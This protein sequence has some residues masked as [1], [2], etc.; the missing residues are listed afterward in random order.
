MNVLLS[1]STVGIMRYRLDIQ[2]GQIVNAYSSRE[3]SLKTIT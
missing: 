2:L 1:P 3:T